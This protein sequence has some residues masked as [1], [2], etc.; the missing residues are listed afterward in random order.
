M[1]LPAPGQHLL[2]NSGAPGDR[3]KKRV[4]PGTGQKDRQA[5]SDTPQRSGAFCHLP[6]RSSTG[7]LWRRVPWTPHP[8]G[9]SGARRS[10]PAS[11]QAVPCHLVVTT[12]TGSSYL[13]TLE[14]LTFNHLANSICVRPDSL[15]A[16]FSAVP[17]VISSLILPSVDY[18]IFPI[19]CTARSR[20]FSDLSAVLF[21]HNVSCSCTTGSPCVSGSGSLRRLTGCWKSGWKPFS[22]VSR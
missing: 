3:W 22:T 19:L 13:L 2:I 16:F 11:R 18:N 21:I 15:R 7:D 14:K 8:R 17:N 10:G 5:E 4:P 6:H 20:Y 1:V 12:V 9:R